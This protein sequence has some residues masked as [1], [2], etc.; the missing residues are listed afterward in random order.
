MCVSTWVCTHEY[1]WPQRP[2]KGIRPPKTRVT[3]C[4][5]PPDMDAGELNLVPLQEHQV[6]S[7]I[8]PLVTLYRHVVQ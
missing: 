3:G 8:Q 4:C 7:G 5:K 2:E 6:F 1:R